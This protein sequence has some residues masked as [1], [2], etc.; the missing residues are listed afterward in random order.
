MELNGDAGKQVW[1][2]E[3]GWTTDTV[4]PDRAFYAVT[5]EQQADYIVR[6]FQYARQYWQ[7]WVGP[8]FVWN[9]PDPTWAPDATGVYPEQYYWGI[10]ETDGTPRP[11]YTALANARASG[12][13][14]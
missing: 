8:M 12:L 10:T 3:F 6:A 11:A 5:P 13:L 14:P 2:N 4:H 7:P 1:I 9:I